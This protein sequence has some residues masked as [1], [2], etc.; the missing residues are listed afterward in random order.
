M[1]DSFVL[2]AYASLAASRTYLQWLLACPNFTLGSEDL[3]LLQMKKVISMNYDSS[4]SSWKPW[5]WVRLDL[6]FYMRDIYIN[7]NLNP[8]TKFTSSSRSTEF[9]DILQWNICQMIT[10]TMPTS[11]RIVISYA[12]KQGIPFWVYWKV[13][14]NL[15][16]NMIRI[17]QW[18]K[19]SDVADIC[20]SMVSL[21]VRNF[22]VW[23]SGTLRLFATLSKA[24]KPDYFE[25]HSSLKFSF[26]NIFRIFPWLEL[27]WHS[28]SML[29]KPGWLNWFWQFLCERSP[30]FNP[31]GF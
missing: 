16:N 10:K 29:D 25:L 7:S 3:L 9:K 17:S 20:I 28:C 5:R 19:C 12:M 31:K 24:C 22:N 13:N 21:C 23:S 15:Y 2:V 18:R 26:M 30:S 11:T 8:V 6:I 4:T 27:F 1:M 14:G